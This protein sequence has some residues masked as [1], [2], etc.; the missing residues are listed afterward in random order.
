MR[1][2]YIIPAEPGREKRV[3][4]LAWHVPAPLSV[5]CFVG[6][7]VMFSVCVRNLLFFHLRFRLLRFGNV[8]WLTLPWSDDH[9][10]SWLS[11]PASHSCRGNTHERCCFILFRITYGIMVWKSCDSEKDSKRKKNHV[12]W[13][14]MGVASFVL[15]SFQDATY[16]WTEV[17]KTLCC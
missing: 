10:W 13:N 14:D 7:V 15:S 5:I 2:G 11:P 1:L 12:S 3:S 8:L 16:L 6:M 4:W 9:Q 17:C